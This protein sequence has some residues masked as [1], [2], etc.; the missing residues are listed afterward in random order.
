M[1]SLNLIVII[2]IFYSLMACSSDE[3]QKKSA[4]EVKRVK[5]I[6]NQIFVAEIGGMVCKMGCGG[7]IRKSLMQT[8]AVSRVE[9]EFEDGADRQLI[10]VHFN[11]EMI[12]QNEII[13]LLEKINNKQFKVY[14][15]GL[16]HHRKAT[17]SSWM[18]LALVAPK[19]PST[20]AKF[21]YNF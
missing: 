6:S 13:H 16:S 15:I 5:V 7:S 14:P 18:F 17:R 20:K 19:P 8:N 9:I 11:K 21:S 3:K 10:R 2:T 4:N 1:K 12:S